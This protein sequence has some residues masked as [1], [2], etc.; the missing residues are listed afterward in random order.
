MKPLF[1]RA[2]VSVAFLL[3]LSRGLSGQ[4]IVTSASGVV[5]DAETSEPVPYASVM[6]AGT[7]FG[8][9]A[10]EE[11]R[12]SLS[13]PHGFSTLAVQML[14]YKT[15]IV[16]IMPGKENDGLR[17]NLEID[18]FGIDAVTVKPSRRKNKYTR[19]NNPAVDLIREVIAHKDDNRLA[20]KDFYKARTYEKLVMSLDKFDVDFDSSRFWR[21]FTFI[22]D[23]LDTS[24][25]NASPVLSGS[26][27]ESIY[28]DYYRKRPHTSKRIVHYRNMQGVDKILDREGLSANLDQMLQSVD[29]FSDNMEI[30]LNSFVSPLSSSLATSYY[31]YYIMDTLAVSGSRCVDLAFVPVN[32][33]GYGFTGHLYITTDG[34]YALKKYTLNVPANINLNFVS[35]LSISSEFESLEDGMLVPVRY[36][37]YANF[38]IFKKMRQIYA[39]QSRIITGYEFDVPEEEKEYAFAIQGDS[40]TDEGAT[41]LRKQEWVGIRPEPLKKSESLIDSLVIELEKVPK[42]RATMKTCE[43]M[44]S[45]YIPTSRVRTKS[46]FDFGPIWNTISWN[47]L[48]GV[49]LRLGGMTTANLNPHFFLNG[50]VAFG[51]KDLRVKYSASAIYSLRPKEYHAYEHFRNAFY[52]TSSYDVQVPGQLFSVFD[53][54]CILMSLNFGPKSGKYEYVL[55]NQ[56]K[57]EIEWPSRIGLEVW[58]AHHNT[59]AAGLMSFDRYLEDGTTRHIDKFNDITLGMKFRFAPGERI[60]NNRM[61]R[62]SLFNLSNEA[63][64]LEFAHEIGYMEGGYMFNRSEFTAQKRFWLSSFG[65]I[66]ATLNAGIE[67]NKVPFVKLFIPYTNQSLFLQPTTFNMMQPMEFLTDQYVSLH[68]T[69]YMKGLILNRIP[70]VKKLKLREV[71]SFSALYGTLSRKNNPA[72]SPTGLFVFP[73]GAGVMGKYPYMEMSVGIENI[74]KVIRVDY[75]R[76]LNYL[77]NTAAHKNGVRVSLRFSF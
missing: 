24:T 62:S 1:M 26:L 77:G 42:F 56:L 5:L 74:L 13:N 54:D 60:F 33:E 2:A 76:R 47:R 38:Y 20:S 12:F 72:V 27:R 44:F 29:I 31:K 17:I 34:R 36:D 18:G 23:Y 40:E 48:E 35:N 19:K 7:Q 64:V 9:M 68:L 71:V 58:L 55:T 66:D 67:W 37:T 65:H 32:S 59:E 16:P 41:S 63:P 52:I 49:R 45:G 25:F 6:F 73:E 28:D 61:G 11:G 70:L 51:C 14:S 8:T 69:Y 4:E 57:Y 43:A 53:R 3:A 30:L 22:K 39:H 50:Y 21:N 10:D 15:A 46:K 75:V